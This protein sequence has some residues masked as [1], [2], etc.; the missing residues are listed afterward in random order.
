M[1]AKKINYEKYKT[2]L[3]LIVKLFA[4]EYRRRTLAGALLVIYF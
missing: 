3:F 2:G 1:E 4:T